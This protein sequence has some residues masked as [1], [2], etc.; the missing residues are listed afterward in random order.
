MAVYRPIIIRR[1]RG[2]AAPAAGAE[3]VVWKSILTYASP[4]RACEYAMEELNDYTHDVVPSHVPEHDGGGWFAVVTTGGA[5]LGVDGEPRRHVVLK[6]DHEFPADLRGR[7][8][9]RTRGAALLSEL[10]AETLEIH[11]PTTA[12]FQPFVRIDSG[13][14]IAVGP[15][16]VGLGRG[17][18]IIANELAQ[19]CVVVDQRDDG[20][21]YASIRGDGQYLNGVVWQTASSS[22]QAMTAW[23]AAASVFTRI[24]SGERRVRDEAED[25][26]DE[27]MVVASA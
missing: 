2:E 9:A 14:E 4:E 20:D 18:A 16:V 25:A 21:W 11:A 22:G 17:D 15:P 26:Q 27:P 1:R 24:S 23:R 10:V 8:D 13:N 6:D 19:L 3:Q 5:G 12:R 7:T